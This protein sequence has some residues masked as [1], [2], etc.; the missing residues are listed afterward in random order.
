FDFAFTRANV[1]DGKF[2]YGSASERTRYTRALVSY[3]NPANNYDTDVPAA[4]DAKLQRRYGDNPVEIS[5]IGCTRE[6]EAQRR[7]KWILL[8]NSQDRTV[9]FRV[10][11]DGHI[12][13]PGHVIPVADKLISGAEIGGR[14]SAAAGTVIT[15]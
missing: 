15:L 6:S 11:M 14:I 9:T 3:D 13:L 5:A 4:S 12:P 8:T 1:I 7:G 10:G 2:N